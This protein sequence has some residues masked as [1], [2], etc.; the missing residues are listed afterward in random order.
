MSRYIDADV[1]FN[2]FKELNIEPYNTFSTVDAP[3]VV[4]CIACIHRPIIILW[5]G[6]EYIDAPRDSFGWTD[7]TCPMLCEDE[8]RYSYV[9]PDD[10]WCKYGERK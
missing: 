6:R 4:R 10:F 1:F 2:T 8:E 7:W 9:P 5:A 3:E